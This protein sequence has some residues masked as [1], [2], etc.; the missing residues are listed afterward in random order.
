M[1]DKR[2]YRLSPARRRQDT[3]ERHKWE[4]YTHIEKRLKAEGLPAAE[5]RRRMAAERKRLGI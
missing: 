1:R 4:I 2:P 5:I 3:R